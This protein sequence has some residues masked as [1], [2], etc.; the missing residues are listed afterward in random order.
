M[1]FKSE[2]K[3]LRNRIAIPLL[4]WGGI[5][6]IAGIFYLFISSDLIKGVLLQALFWGL[7]DAIIGIVSLFRKKK[8]DLKKIK[9]ILLI[10]VYLDVLYIIIGVVLVLLGS[11]NFMIG[12][13]YGLIIQGL[14][15]FIVDLIHHNHIKKILNY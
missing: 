11:S 3:T 9:K 15:L 8:I 1:N 4:I 12:N 13:G 5:N 10:N 2:N 7:I 6:I 14:F